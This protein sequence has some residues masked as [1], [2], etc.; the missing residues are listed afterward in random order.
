MST[1]RS[2]Q[3]VTFFQQA[4]LHIFGDGASLPKH[5][6]YYDSLDLTAQVA[7]AIAFL[8]TS[9]RVREFLGDMYHFSM[10]A[11]YEP[12]IW[13]SIITAYYP[14]LCMRD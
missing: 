13:G 1:Y 12:V 3:T 10:R 4:V 8:R 5:K 14:E 2:I 11:V 7:E 6:G 9:P